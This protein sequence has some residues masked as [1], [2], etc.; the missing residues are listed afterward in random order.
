MLKPVIENNC[1]NHEVN[2]QPTSSLTWYFP[3]SKTH[4][5]IVRASN[6]A[7]SGSLRLLAKHNEP[8]T[9]DLSNPLF[10]YY[11][12]VCII[13]GNYLNI[14]LKHV[15]FFLLIVKNPFLFFSSC[16]TKSTVDIKR[17]H[18]ITINTTEINE[19]KA[20]SS[21]IDIHRRSE[22]NLLFDLLEMILLL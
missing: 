2:F 10:L 18:Q 7:S 16:W 14:L 21:R 1:I 5:M 12:L 15:P 9:I 22:N 17:K 11:L 3:L 8:S 6:R 4:S 13:C 19:T 20:K